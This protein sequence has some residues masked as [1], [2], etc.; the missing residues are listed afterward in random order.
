MARKG[1]GKNAFKSNDMDA[2]KGDLSHAP[3][4]RPN[5]FRMPT[6]SLRPQK[7]Q[8][9]TDLSGHVR[10]KLMAHRYLK[11][12]REKSAGTGYTY[13]ISKAVTGTFRIRAMH[14]GKRMATYSLPTLESVFS[15]AGDYTGHSSIVNRI[16]TIGGISV[17]TPFD[18]ISGG[19]VPGMTTSAMNKLV[20]QA[21]SATRWAPVARPGQ[22]FTPIHGLHRH[23]YQLDVGGDPAVVMSQIKAIKASTGL[24][25][26]PDVATETPFADSPFNPQARLAAYRAS[27]ISMF[28]G[29][30]KG[31]YKM[32]QQF[33][34]IPFSVSNSMRSAVRSMPAAFGFGHV[35]GDIAS[36]VMFHGRFFE[37]GFMY[38][39]R[40]IDPRTGRAIASRSSPVPVLN[41][42]QRL[43]FGSAAANVFSD[44]DQAIAATDVLGMMRRGIQGNLPAGHSYRG[45]GVGSATH[46]FL[47]K[48][49]IVGTAHS[50]VLGAGLVRPFM[51]SDPALM[52]EMVLGTYQMAMLKLGYDKPK[53]IR[54]LR[55]A[56]GSKHLR[57]AGAGGAWADLEGRLVLKGFEQGKFTE[58]LGRLFDV[59][60][61]PDA[62]T[63]QL[64]NMQR[65]TSRLSRVTGLGLG[66]LTN[67]GLL[68]F[69]GGQLTEALALGGIAQREQDLYSWGDSLSSGLNPHRGLR[70]TKE[71]IWSTRLA[72]ADKLADYLQ[73]VRRD[74]AIVAHMKFRR[75][76]MQSLAH[77]TGAGAPAAVGSTISIDSL[78]GGKTAEFRSWFNATKAEYAARAV[79][80]DRTNFGLALRQFAQKSGLTNIE[81]LFTTSPGFMVDLGGVRDIGVTASI[82]NQQ[83]ALAGKLSAVPI[84]NFANDEEYAYRVA[85]FLADPQDSRSL[86]RLVAESMSRFTAGEG[87]LYA[88]LFNP[89]LGQAVSARIQNPVSL[90]AGQSPE[91]RFDAAV[92]AHF[93]KLGTNYDKGAQYV[94]ASQRMF[95]KLD[96]ATKALIQKQGY[97]N[98]M[99]QRWPETGRSISA[100]R[101]IFGGGMVKNTN[102]FMMKRASA[103]YLLGDVDADEASIVLAS[104]DKKLR[105][106]LLQLEDIQRKPLAEQE[107]IQRAMFASEAVSEGRQATNALFKMF[108]IDDSAQWDALSK[109]TPSAQ[110][111]GVLA[112]QTTKTMTPLVDPLVKFKA[113]SWMAASNKGLIKL[114]AGQKTAMLDFIPA[115][116]ES[117][118]TK[119]AGTDTKAQIEELNQQILSAADKILAGQTPDT[120]VGKYRSILA[121][122]MSLFHKTKKGAA[123]IAASIGALGGDMSFYDKMTG[124][125]SAEDFSGLLSSQ[126]STELIQAMIKGDLLGLRAKEALSKYALPDKKIFNLGHVK[127]LQLSGFGSI[128]TTDPMISALAEMGGYDLVTEGYK[129][130]R[131]QAIKQEAITASRSIG[132]T[133]AKGLFTGVVDTILSTAYKHKG[134]VAA[135][136]VAA[137]G[138]TTLFGLHTLGNMVG[139]SNHIAQ[140]QDAVPQTPQ[141]RYVMSPMDAWGMDIQMQGKVGP[142]AMRFAMGVA[143]QAPGQTDVRIMDSRS[144]I[145]DRA[146]GFMA[147]DKSDSL[148]FRRAF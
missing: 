96:P 29:L 76:G 24:K 13:D 67:M 84:G 103:G 26:F 128:D 94:F 131:G 88:N 64:A 74:P 8:T 92:A 70:I 54:A 116:I 73:A 40:N 80:G 18:V 56:V 129:A 85:S 68:R 90:I 108:G 55:A 28:G 135:V 19:F 122:S 123:N 2:A 30:Y 124:V 45:L 145:S 101:V 139:R 12:L 117:A 48:T 134:K 147:E 25:L 99:L 15:G 87:S 110:L 43:L 78:L 33:R 82:H 98:A 62:A 42:P 38:D 113:W 63:K 142:E 81:Q 141:T 119:H 120:L 22:P 59:D 146:L 10:T 83:Q 75:S 20:A 126:Q 47:T 91:D 71:A 130:A 41:I 106:A 32:L 35:G 79:P 77:L 137:A 44:K 143:N 132:A 1:R 46:G 121:D 72:G 140:Q 60:D 31:G 105:E 133:S 21:T 61:A 57:R 39:H 118:I 102:A 7:L 17:Q 111:A 6:P 69:K 138:M 34:T 97:A 125:V 144:P 50:G 4:I 37:T 51:R 89:K 36:R 23:Q 93:N 100:A 114:N 66:D 14:G 107:R 115:M 52:M 9:D 5:Q 49:N 53:M 3:A 104:G 109:A 95:N 148:Y 65:L 27:D 16:K 86:N 127:K 136:G 58:G 112:A 11:M